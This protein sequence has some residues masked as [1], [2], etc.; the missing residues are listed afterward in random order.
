MK[1]STQN[2]GSGIK[3]ILSNLKL[4]TFLSNDSRPKA[5]LIS[6]CKALHSGRTSI[7]DL[8]TAEHVN[9]AQGV[10][11]KSVKRTNSNRS[12][13][14]DNLPTSSGRLEQRQD[15]ECTLE[16]R[17][18]Y[19]TRRRGSTGELGPE[20]SSLEP[21]EDPIFGFQTKPK[22]NFCDPPVNQYKGLD[23]DPRMIYSTEF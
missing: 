15:S 5:P 14:L 13:S 10:G 1:S 19:C 9:F 21:R 6:L 17:A 20:T 2:S 23:F 3:G 12:Y 22:V 7:P 4:I 18:V 16:D 11:P 8:T